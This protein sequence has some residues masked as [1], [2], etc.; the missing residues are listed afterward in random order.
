[1]QATDKPAW[2]VRGLSASLRAVNVVC[3]WIVCL[4]TCCERGLG[5][6]FTRL[7]R[8]AC[9]RLFAEAP[10]VT[11]ITGG[12]TPAWCYQTSPAVYLSSALSTDTL[13]CASENVRRK[14]IICDLLISKPPY[15]W[16]GVSG[17]MIERGVETASNTN[18]EEEILHKAPSCHRYGTHCTLT[19]F[20]QV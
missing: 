10:R 12:V 16:L 19:N 9:T 7:C 8:S 4:C 11:P 17:R 5:E 3:T 14:P 1:M 15:L 13:F 18:A 20:Q 6:V 2:T